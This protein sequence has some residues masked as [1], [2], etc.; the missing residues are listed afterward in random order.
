MLGTEVISLRDER[1]TA[2]A[3]LATL[4]ANAANFE[5]QKRLLIEAREELVREFQNTGSKVLSKAQEDFLERANE[6]FGH[7]E[8]SSEEKIRALLAPVGEKLKNYE[9]QV[10]SLEAKRV[11]AF[12]QL[13]G[14]ID[15]MRVGQD[16]VRE[17]AARL[18]NS[19]RNGN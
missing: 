3:E 19:L 5:E 8:K 13:T 17:E 7:A 1:D 11:D 4:K 14:L 6:R 2:R 12:G 18:G 10:A 15:S 9:E 16:K